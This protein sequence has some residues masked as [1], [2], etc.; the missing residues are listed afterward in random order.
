MRRVRVER[1]VGQNA[2][3]VTM[4]LF[5]G[6]NG[7]AH[8][9]VGVKRLFTVLAAPLWLRVWEQC[10]A[11][12]AKIDSFSGAHNDLVNGPA[13]YAGQRQ[14]RFFDR[15]SLGDEQWPDKICRRK[16]GLTDHGSAPLGGARAAQT[17][18]REK[19]CVAHEGQVAVLGRILNGLSVG[20]RMV[21][22]KR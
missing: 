11:G 20:P 6:A 21:D 3:C 8:Q 4:C 17:G 19:G 12:N 2:D 14:N 13:R 1:D 5:D 18:V 9:I 7:A 10:D 22:L 15:L 16:H